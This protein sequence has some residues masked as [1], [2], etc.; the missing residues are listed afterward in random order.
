MSVGDP[1][2]YGAVVSVVDG[3]SS[4]LAVDV[5]EAVLVIIGVRVDVDVIVCVFE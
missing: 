2:K 1:V 3:D 4:A 5:I